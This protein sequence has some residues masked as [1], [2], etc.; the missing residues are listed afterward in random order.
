MDSYLAKSSA[1]GYA[2]GATATLSTDTNKVPSS[3]VHWS[4]S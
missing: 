3:E 4:A 1:L 2:L